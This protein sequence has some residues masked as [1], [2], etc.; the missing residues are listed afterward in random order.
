MNINQA[1]IILQ[2]MVN[3]G[4]VI[5]GLNKKDRFKNKKFLFGNNKISTNYIIKTLRPKINLQVHS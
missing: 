1:S 4:Q 2:K 3:K 5:T